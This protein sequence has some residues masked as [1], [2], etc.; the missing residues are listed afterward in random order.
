MKYLITLFLI[1]I[2]LSQAGAQE[3]R[4]GSSRS[5]GEVLFQQENP[6]SHTLMHI[7]GAIGQ[8][9][10]TNAIIARMGSLQNLTPP[11]LY[12]A[13]FRYIEQASI[14][15]EGEQLDLRI[16]IK[17][18]GFTTLPS[19]GTTSNQKRQ[20]GFDYTP[21]L[22][23]D[24][25]NFRVQLLNGQGNILYEQVF[26][27][28]DIS[29]I[30]T[31]T[32]FL[33][34]ANIQLSNEFPQSELKLRMKEIV[35]PAALLMFYHSSGRKEKFFQHLTMVA[36]YEKDA[37]RL[38]EMIEKAKLLSPDDPD[39]LQTRLDALEEYKR[40]VDE[41]I[42]ADYPKKLQLAKNDPKGLIRQLETFATVYQEKKTALQNGLRNLDETYY[43]KGMEFFRKRDLVNAML[44]FN[45]SVG[46]NPSHLK[47]NYQIALIDFQQGRIDL[48]EGRLNRMVTTMNPDRQMMAEV[49]K[50]LGEIRAEKAKSYIAEYETMIAVAEREWKR[51]RIPEAFGELN[52]ATRYQ[53]QNSQYVTT[54]DLVFRMA[55]RIVADLTQNPER[56]V[57]MKQYSQAIRKYDEIIRLCA[58]YGGKLVHIG[59]LENRIHEI[60]HLEIDDEVQ[61]AQQALRRGDFSKA[62][63]FLNQISEI[64][65]QNP[66]LSQNNAL[67]QLLPQYQGAL[68]VAG[69]K[70]MFDKS[71]GKAFELLN[72]CLNMSQQYNLPVPQDLSRLLD[73]ARTGVFVSILMS[74][75]DA[76]GNR[77]FAGA[78]YFLKEALHFI[79][80][81][82]SQVA[83][84]ALEAYKSNLMDSYIDEG[85]RLMGMKQFDNAIALF[86][87]AQ[88]AQYTFGIQ[89]QERIPG[90]ITEAREGISI[91]MLEGAQSYLDRKNYIQ[92]LEGI[93]EAAQYMTDHSL[94]GQAQG[95]L[96]ITADNYYREALQQVDVSNRGKQYEAALEM[97]GDIRYICNYFPVRCELG[98]VDQREKTSRQGIYNGLVSEAE[99]AFGKNDLKTATQKVQD[100]QQYQQVWK[101]YITTSKEADAISGKIR[102]KSYQQAIATGKSYADKRDF[103]QALGYY[104]EA[105][106]LEREGGFA[107]D[108]KLP[109]YRKN[110]A[111]HTLM[112]DADQLEQMLGQASYM[113]TKDKM[114]QIMTLRTRY[115]LQDNK[116]LE[117][118]LKSIQVRMVSAACL[119]QQSLYDEHMDAAYKHAQQQGF[120]AAG[121]EIRKAI[122]AANRLAECEISDSSASRYLVQLTPAIR[123]QEKME[124]A[125]RLLNGSKHAEAVTAY[126]EAERVFNEAHAGVFGLKHEPF[127]TYVVNQNFNY[128]LAAAYHFNE[129][130]NIGEALRMIEVLATKGY[131]SGQTRFL[132]EQI[133]FKLGKQ[134]RLKYEGSGWKVAVMKHTRG[135]KFYKYFRSAYKKGWK[136]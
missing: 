14:V 48:A 103:R 11:T 86:G 101:Q 37:A 122:E 36:A 55:D 54:N 96:S 124:E 22:I 31:S 94:A 18:N 26:E 5:N 40:V 87:R 1:S 76:M 10:H 62:G 27:G 70:L 126:L 110:A 44:W 15:R 65:R 114:L 90:L 38:D 24:Q 109:G 98:V 51:G 129:G 100:A 102:Q 42:N 82:P 74:G 88:E 134:D 4:S 19:G 132:Q 20:S 61:M 53:E 111:F 113:A 117:V 6:G 60:L 58:Q 50:L 93:K 34:I 16:S 77:D 79:E 91:S 118:K 3:A 136:G 105:N 46:L 33:E 75:Q 12:K 47:S 28:V 69:Q 29:A 130:G 59:D 133:G 64:Y 116:E 99:Q 107:F 85:R 45:K 72:G 13:E 39:K 35:S 23:P 83:R 115:D 127:T 9:E 123:Y 2:S 21:F 49:Q 92:A 112:S 67:N 57:Q 25:M 30:S 89:G 131:P 104:D 43:N 68:F 121:E 66:G 80:N 8:K 108:N 81:R 128:I 78:E 41:I 106:Q 95:K 125:N 17:Q 73:E 120:I 84:Q 135:E 71:Y 32:A 119:Q 97:I 7:P 56:D 52:R 63:E